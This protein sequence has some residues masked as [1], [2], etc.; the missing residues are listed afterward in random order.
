M[1]LIGS[2]FLK[3]LFIIAFTVLRVKCGSGSVDLTI[4]IASVKLN[5]FELVFKAFIDSSSS[6]VQLCEAEQLR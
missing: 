5:W 2:A 4:K 6:R 1:L 3:L